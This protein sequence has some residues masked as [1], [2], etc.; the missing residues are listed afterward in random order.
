MAIHWTESETKA[1]I[2][3][4]GSEEIQHKLI[5]TVRNRNTYERVALELVKNR[6]DRSWK[7]C[8]DRIKSI[9]AKYHKT[10]D[11]NRQ[12]GSKRHNCLYYSEIGA[13]ISTHPVSV[14]PVLMKV[15]KSPLLIQ[16]S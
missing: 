3:I 7:Q 9:L 16:N 6:V 8:R 12:T 11:K 5:G 4:W 14:S 13:I 15:T 10:K 1:T 2:T